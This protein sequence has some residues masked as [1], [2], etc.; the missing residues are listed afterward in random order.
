M[1]SHKGALLKGVMDAGAI[2]Y[3]EVSVIVGLY[4]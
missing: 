2:F 1:L 4:M 3:M